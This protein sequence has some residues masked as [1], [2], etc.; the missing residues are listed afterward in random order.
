MDHPIHPENREQEL[1]QHPCLLTMQEDVI[2]R[3]LMS[4][5]NGAFELY[6]IRIQFV[7]PIFTQLPIVK[8]LLQLVILQSFS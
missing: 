5:T 8:L 7:H 3:L 4:I 6:W 1:P 2:N